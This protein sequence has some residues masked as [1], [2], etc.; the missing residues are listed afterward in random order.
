[1]PASSESK[2]LCNRIRSIRDAARGIAT[3]VASQ[4]N[5]RIHAGATGVV[6]A[7]GIYFGLS[8]AEWCWIVLAIVIVWTAEGLNTSLE[9]LADFSSP[10]FHP[11]V[12]QAKDV[13]AGAVLIAAIGSAVIG[14]LVFGPHVLEL[15]RN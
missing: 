3:L 2:M 4:H 14:F 5:A 9:L 12:K 11:L 10:G 1:M 6:L 8:R 7:L 13:A 15:L